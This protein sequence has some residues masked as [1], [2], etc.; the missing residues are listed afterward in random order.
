MDTGLVPAPG[1]EE[2]VEETVRAERGGR[3]YYG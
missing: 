1:D 3:R 2:G